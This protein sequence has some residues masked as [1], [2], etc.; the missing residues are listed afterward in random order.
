MVLICVILTVLTRLVRPVDVDSQFRPALNTRQL[1]AGEVYIAPAILHE[2]DGFLFSIIISLGEPLQ[3]LAVSVDVEVQHYGFM[4]GTFPPGVKGY[5]QGV[6]LFKPYQS[7]TNHGK[8]R[9]S[10]HHT[11][12]TVSGMLVNM[13]TILWHLRVALKSKLSFLVSLST[14]ASTISTDM[15]SWI[16]VMT[17]RNRVLFHGMELLAPS[18]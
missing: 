8:K 14:V 2:P 3:E 9:N 13:E 5:A 1:D 17:T 4:T 16:R 11:S 15:Q 6:P 12:L 7:P 10:T 18:L